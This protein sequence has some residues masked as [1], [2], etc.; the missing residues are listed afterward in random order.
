M[1]DQHNMVANYWSKGVR[2]LTDYGNEV[3]IFEI[4]NDI[5]DTVIPIVS[6]YELILRGEE[7]YLAYNQDST[8][9]CRDI[10]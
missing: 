4:K 2:L 5:R 10:D 6:A 7:A 3:L 9:V 8:A 1:V